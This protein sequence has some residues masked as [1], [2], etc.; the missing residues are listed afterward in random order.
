MGRGGRRGG[1]I[2]VTLPFPS[3]TGP[4]TSSSTWLAEQGMGVLR[5]KDGHGTVP[6]GRGLCFQL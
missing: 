1:L 2:E 5:S 6:G 4:Q 3:T